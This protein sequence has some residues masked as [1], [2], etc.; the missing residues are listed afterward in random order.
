MIVIVNW[1]SGN[2]LFDCLES[3]RFNY[4]LPIVVVDNGSTD[5]SYLAVK[6]FENVQLISCPI[7]N[8]FASA[9]NLGAREIDGDYVLFLNPDIKIYP[10]AIEKCLEFMNEYT[11][12]RVGICGVQLVD[13]RSNISRSCSRFPT[14]SGFLMQSLGIDKLFPAL[15]IPMFDWD[16]KSTAKV[17]Q[18]IGAFFMVRMK[19][20]KDLSGFDERFFVYCEEVDFSYRASL[21]GWSSVYIA[22]ANAFHYGGGSSE[23]VKSER[24]F[25]RL[26]SRILYSFKH[27]SMPGAVLILI[28]TLLIEPI[29]R[30]IFIM[31]GMS[32]SGYQEA[33]RG[34][35]L[36]W[37]WFLHWIRKGVIR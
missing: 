18:V 33:W 23:K 29:S 7:N 2:F 5:F 36:L 10:G 11:N 37:S 30:G 22:E 28:T 32:Q 12:S 9:C 16:H 21:K 4:D 13:V 14:V 3:I 25:Y 27:F 20:F 1:N 31:F 15:G 24:Q 34:Y 8:G 26:R 35:R 6:E 19:L 17:D